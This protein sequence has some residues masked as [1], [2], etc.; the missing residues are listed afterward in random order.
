MEE[1][2]A[3]KNILIIGLGRFGRHC[4]RKLNEMGHQVMAVD[5]R[6]DRVDAV[7][8]YVTDGLIG[9]STR[10]DFMKTLAVRSYDVCIVAIGD[11]FQSS[12]E[13]TALL[14]DL[15]AQY[16]VARAARDVHARF[17]A[18]NG[19]DEVIYPEKSMGVRVARNLMSSGFLDIFELSS[20]FSMAE[21][22]VPQSWV[23]KN[24]ISLKIREKYKINIIGIKVGD[25][26][27]VD[28]NPEAPLP[29]EAALIAVG[30][31]RDLNKVSK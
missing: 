25:E 15:D 21:F 30:K 2:Q 1:K 4:A 12:L 3:M 26:V 17:L 29:A 28:L 11:D 31:N 7:L 19:A 6:E 23:G 18:R 14:K 16:V 5:V 9:N 20:D 22:K 8:P 13:T 10:M 27:T 24:L